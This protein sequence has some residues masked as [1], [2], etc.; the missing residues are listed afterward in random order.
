MATKQPKKDQA[1]PPAPASALGALGANT[2]PTPADV[3]AALEEDA[4]GDAVASQAPSA[5]DTE[6][7]F[8]RMRASLPAAIVADLDQQS[9]GETAAVLFAEVC[10][11]YGIDPTPSKREILGYRAYR[12]NLAENTPERV[13]LVTAGGLKIDAPMS[14][15]TEDALRRW[16]RAFQVDRKT[17]ETVALPLP[18][19]LT[20]PREAVTGIAATNTHQMPG[21]YL[22]SRA[23]DS[24]RGGR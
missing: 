12:E 19:D 2:N 10:A 17:G 11:V 20:L 14:A 22:R 8:G 7:Y 4:A 3:I 21:G 16:Y 24:V 9:G 23:A 6:E 15:Q 1:E 18:P 13:A 5:G